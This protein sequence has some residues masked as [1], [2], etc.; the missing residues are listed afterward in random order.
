MI[1]QPS[2]F[3]FY[4]SEFDIWAGFS[5]AVQ[6]PNTKE[7]S[8]SPNRLVV[9]GV[10][11]PLFSSRGVGPEGF[12]KICYIIRSTAALSISVALGMYPPNASSSPGQQDLN[13]ELPCGSQRRR[14]ANE[15]PPSRSTDCHWLPPYSIPTRTCPT[16][17]LSTQIIPL[18]CG[19]KHTSVSPY[20]RS[21]RLE[22]HYQPIPEHQVAL[23]SRYFGTSPLEIGLSPRGRCI[24]KSAEKTKPNLVISAS[25]G[26]KRQNHDGRVSRRLLSRF[27]APRRST[28]SQKAASS[29]LQVGQ[30]ARRI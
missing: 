10:H 22:F 2:G 17:A 21:G 29:G 8:P 26:P 18:Q 16:E 20:P 15:L 23:N 12:N 24:W 9:H 19:T 1:K 5:T 28:S 7:T 11:G 3:Q 6:S 25:K 14:E 30:L 13:C 4:L 27:R